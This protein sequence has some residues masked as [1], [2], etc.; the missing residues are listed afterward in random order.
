VRGNSIDS[1]GAEGD[2]GGSGSPRSARSVAR[3]DSTCPEAI[4]IS[5]VGLDGRGTAAVRVTCLR[6]IGICE[7]R[8]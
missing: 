1:G 4:Q 8:H 5:C 7:R 6:G 2:A 3:S